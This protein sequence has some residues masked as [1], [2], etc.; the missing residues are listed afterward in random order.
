VQ[1]ETDPSVVQTDD[2]RALIRTTRQHGSQVLQ[3][4]SV[5]SA[6]LKTLIP[7]INRFKAKANL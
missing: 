6:E 3:A 7:V 5:I 4:L 2:T 1:L